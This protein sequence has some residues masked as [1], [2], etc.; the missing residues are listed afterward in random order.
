MTLQRIVILC[1]LEKV[2][3]NWLFVF[4]A[5]PSGNHLGD[6]K[7]QGG[8]T[9]TNLHVWSSS[10][11]PHASTLRAHFWCSSVVLFTNPISIS[12][13]VIHPLPPLD[14]L[15]RNSTA[16]AREG[17]EKLRL[18]GKIPAAH[19]SDF[20]S[21]FFRAL[22]AMLCVGIFDLPFCWVAPP[23]GVAGSCSGN[24]IIDENKVFLF[25]VEIWWFA[26]GLKDERKKMNKW[27]FQWLDSCMCRFG[28]VTL[29]LAHPVVAL[30]HL[31]PDPSSIEAPLAP[32]LLM[33]LHLVNWILSWPKNDLD[34]ALIFLVARSFRQ[35]FSCACVCCS[36]LAR[37]S[38]CVP[39]W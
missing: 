4:R 9:M 13:P 7:P 38:V 33:Y 24:Y 19:A 20:S 32:T 12:R 1:L 36:L 23:G 21:L 37:L 15:R 28:E 18:V 17:G 39:T 22:R 29:W 8:P 3:S 6:R 30:R 27:L 14:L 25:S 16:G 2:C 5:P 31:L 11:G 10:S 35:R 26:F 34:T